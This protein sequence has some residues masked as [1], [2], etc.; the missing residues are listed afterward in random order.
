MCEIVLIFAH[1]CANP[2][3]AR[4]LVRAKTSMNKV[5]W[6][7]A[8]WVEEIRVLPYFFKKQGRNKIWAPKSFTA[9]RQFV[10]Y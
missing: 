8:P 7:T 9:F 10:R 2:G 4:K 5:S 1:F 3:F 6:P